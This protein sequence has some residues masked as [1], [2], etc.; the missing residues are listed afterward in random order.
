MSDG[1]ARSRQWS[2]PGSAATGGISSGSASE[3]T[4]GA[5]GDEPRFHTAWDGWAEDG[6]WQG[7]SEAPEHG[8][9]T[10]PGSLL[11]KDRWNGRRGRQDNENWSWRNGYGPSA[12]QD[13]G[14]SSWKTWETSYADQADQVEEQSSRASSTTSRIEGEPAPVKMVGETVERKGGKVSSTYPPVFKARP[15]E[16]KRSVEFGLGRGRPTS[17]RTGWAQD[18]GAVERT[19]GSAGE[20]PLQWGREWSRWQGRDLQGTGEVAPDQAA[21]QAPRG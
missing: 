21:G 14:G 19:S 8:M 3:K 18:D 20:A 10:G 17:A 1:Q 16:W 13:G 15:L 9:R 2:R 11:E 7:T 5:D 6:S 12:S 4:R